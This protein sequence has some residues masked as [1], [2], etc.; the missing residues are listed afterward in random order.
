[1]LARFI[2]NL[3]QKLSQTGDIVDTLENTNSF[4]LYEMYVKDEGAFMEYVEK[5][6]NRLE[7]EIE[8]IDSEILNIG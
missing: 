2:T 4:K 5:E 8:A 7:A 3:K 1:M 6:K